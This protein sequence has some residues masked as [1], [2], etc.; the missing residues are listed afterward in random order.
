MIK[1]AEE[2]LEDSSVIVHTTPVYYSTI[3][4]S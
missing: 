2:K 3:K 4:L 1:M